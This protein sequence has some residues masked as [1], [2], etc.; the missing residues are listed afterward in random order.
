MV[1]SDG[2]PGGSMATAVRW[3][4]LPVADDYPRSLLA[5][6]VV[7]AACVGVYFAFGSAGYALVAAAALGGS[8]ARYFLPTD[9]ELDER[10]A[11]IRFLFATRLVPWENV[12]R[13]DVH[14][15]GAFLS[16]FERP[17]RLDS[18]RG[19]FLRFR[20]N[21]DEVIGFVRCRVRSA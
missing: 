6:A 20:G 12:R 1:R 19:S 3:R 18:F 15:D 16:P 4:S 2:T 11:R 13:V 14:R 5:V 8:L 10:G 17:S 7:L 9:Y 21:G